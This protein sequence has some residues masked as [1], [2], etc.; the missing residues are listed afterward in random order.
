[1]IFTTEVNS[2]RKLTKK[3]REDNKSEEDKMKANESYE[4]TV[5]RLKKEAVEEYLK[6]QSDTDAEEE[7]KNNADTD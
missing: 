4:E 6:S 2:I 1:M 5:E 3:V 7:V